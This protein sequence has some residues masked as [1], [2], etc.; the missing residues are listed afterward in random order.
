ML[1]KLDK[2]DSVYETDA[3]ESVHFYPHVVVKIYCSE[4]KIRNK[5]RN[6]FRKLVG[7]K[8]VRSHFKRSRCNHF[9]KPYVMLRFLSGQK[10]K[11]KCNTYNEALKTWKEYVPVVG[12]PNK[13]YAEIVSDDMCGS[14]NLRGVWTPSMFKKGERV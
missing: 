9:E 11:I 6:F 4:S 13:G 2:S 1:K 8:P 7:Y 10:K 3:I 12:T 14:E 5:I